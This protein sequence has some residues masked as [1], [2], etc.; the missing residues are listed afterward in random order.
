MVACRYKLHESV[1]GSL[2]T[3]WVIPENDSDWW[4]CRHSLHESV[5]GSLLTYCVIP[6]NGPDERWSNWGAS[7]KAAYVW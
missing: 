1:A 7:S 6:E 4:A 3:Y 5:A 2:L